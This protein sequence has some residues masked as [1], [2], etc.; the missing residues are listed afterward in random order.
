MLPEVVLATE[1]HRVESD[2]EWR[3]RLSR[4]IENE[5]VISTGSLL[6]TNHV[7]SV[8]DDKSE[9]HD[10]TEASAID[11][12]SGA[13][14]MVAS[15]AGVPWIAIR[16]IVDTSHQRLPAV[17]HS[18]V[19]DS[20]QLRPAFLLEAILKPSD[21]SA[22]FRLSRASSAAGRNMRKVWSLAAPD[23]ALAESQV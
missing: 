3:N 13:V 19:D 14:A 11:M 2:P 16:A 18:A 1:D 12:E 17:V 15:E 4:L 7:V 20:G 22:I 9:L 23:L 8:P 5:V 6:Q 21:L 10:R